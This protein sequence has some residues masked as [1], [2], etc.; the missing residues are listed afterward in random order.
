MQKA[1][2]ILN[3]EWVYYDYYGENNDPNKNRFGKIT[4]KSV[5]ENDRR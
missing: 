1:G 5:M 4:K 3:N 2:E